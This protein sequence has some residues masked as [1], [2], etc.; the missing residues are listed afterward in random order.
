VAVGLATDQSDVILV[1]QKGQ[2]IRFAVSAL[3]DSSRTSG[4]VCGIRLAPDDRVVSMDV[5]CPDS[6]LLVVTTEGFGKLT[7][8]DEYPHQRRAGR[9]VKTFKLTEKTG[10]MAAAKLV[11]QSQ[12]VVIISASGI[13][14]R[15]PVKEKDPK[16]GITIQGRNTQGVRLMR[17]GHNDKVVAITCF[18]K[19]ER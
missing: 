4:G 7:P 3:R 12:E 8:V 1:T 13:V 14:T 18:D 15:T 19:D 9:G 10:E 16:K 11:S 5:A 2:S 6:F 17:L